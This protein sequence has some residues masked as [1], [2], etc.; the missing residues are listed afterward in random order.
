MIAI[1]NFVIKNIIFLSVLLID[2][3]LLK[4]TAFTVLF[5]FMY[6]IVIFTDLIKNGEINKKNIKLLTK[7]ILIGLLFLLSTNFSGFLINNFL[8][9]KTILY[10][11]E[12][13]NKNYKNKE[14][15][16]QLFNYKI[17]YVISDSQNSFIE[18]ELFNYNKFIYLIQKNKFEE[19][20]II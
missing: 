17:I 3:F 16:Y 14:I 2:I 9:N 5:V 15:I 8:K 20:S 11:K 10:S 12:I 18:A 19:Q 4:S 13:N 7:K 6:F 1:N